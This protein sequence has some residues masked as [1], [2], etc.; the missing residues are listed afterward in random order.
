M[1]EGSV[2]VEKRMDA[3]D[4]SWKRPVWLEQVQQGCQL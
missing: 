3:E 1:W 2:G 4:W